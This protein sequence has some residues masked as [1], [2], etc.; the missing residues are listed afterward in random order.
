MDHAPL[1][2]IYHDYIQCLN[3]RNWP[4]LDRFVSDDVI[5]N[6][7][8]LG[9]D[10]YRAMLQ[11]DGRR[12]PDLRFRIEQVVV[13]APRVAARLRFDVAPTGDFLGLAVNGR[14]VNFC[15][16]VFYLFDRGRIA[17]VW[18]VLDKAAI[19]AQLG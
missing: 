12:I 10:G 14:R 3:N 13:Q 19:E 4:A 17:Q 2:A 11:D 18:S 8:R 15:E 16:N 1:D 9:L 7:R 5:H 6:D